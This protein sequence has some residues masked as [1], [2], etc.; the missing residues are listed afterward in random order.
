M[1]KMVEDAIEALKELPE[2]E[3]DTVCRGS[4][5]A[6]MNPTFTCSSNPNIFIASSIASK[7]SA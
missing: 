1:T 2:E 3:Q 5:S 4:G 7:T 6:R